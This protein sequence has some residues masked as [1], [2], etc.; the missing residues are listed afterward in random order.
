M[1]SLATLNL[2]ETAARTGVKPGTSVKIQIPAGK[3]VSFK[4]MSTLKNELKSNAET[5]FY[6]RLQGGVFCT[7]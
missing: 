2:K 1:R 3:K 6:P 5:A 4:V 7:G